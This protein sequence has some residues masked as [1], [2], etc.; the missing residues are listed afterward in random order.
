MKKNHDAPAK[1]DTADRA[2][3]LA[4]SGL[5]KIGEAKKLLVLFNLLEEYERAAADLLWKVARTYYDAGNI[6]VG[7]LRKW[8][9]DQGRMSLKAIAD[10]T[11]FPER[12]ITL[13]LKIFKGFENNPAALEGLT[14]RDALRL[15]APPPPSGEEGYNRIDLNGDPGQAEF[16]FGKVFELPACANHSLQSY[17]TIADAMTEV[18]VLHRTKDGLL[19]SKRFVRFFED[20]PKDPALRHAYK[21]MAQ[22]TQK[23]V[24]DYL[25]ALEQEGVQK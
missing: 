7:V 19:T 2:K 4:A 10:A 24:E 14:M 1:K 17:R 13:A 9:T 23:A 8:R 5:V 15:I 22:K 12:R 3:M 25:A 20:I 21:T 6:L 16:D 18:T 11:G